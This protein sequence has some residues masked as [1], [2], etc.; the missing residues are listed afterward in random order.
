MEKKEP[1]LDTKNTEIE[2]KVEKEETTSLAST[3]QNKKSEN[4][5]NKKVILA[6]LISLIV[7]VA[8]VAFLPS[9]KGDKKVSVTAGKKENFLSNLFKSQKKEMTPPAFDIV[10]MEKGE[11]VIAGTAEK[12]AVVY[13]VDN[14]KKLGSEKADDNG[15]WVFIPKTALKTGNHKLSLYVTGENGNR[16]YAKQNAILHV[17]KKAESEVAVLM[18][19]KKSKVLKAPKG[20]DIGVLRVAKI[21]YN[22]NGIMNIEGLATKN[23]KVNLYMNNNLIVTATTDEF[24]IFVAKAEYKMTDKTKQILRADMMGANGKVLRRV[25]YNFT[26]VFYD[27]KNNM[28]IIKKGDCLWN[29]ALKEY[30]KGTEYLILFEANKSQIKDPNKIYVG[31]VFSVLEKDSNAY[32]DIKA[33]IKQEMKNK[34]K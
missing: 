16:I 34:K 27:G 22:D 25:A 33:K 23:S 2:T 26:P 24:G 7:V 1:I 18:G 17:S 19:N 8:I 28:T 5:K 15:Q 14:G 31:Q 32:N 12:N 10:R 3:K 11:T 4:D 13:I 30:G 29:I 20:Q 9:K 21:S 6:V